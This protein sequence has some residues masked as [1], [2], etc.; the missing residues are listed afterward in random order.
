MGTENFFSNSHTSFIPA[1]PNFHY[2]GGRNFHRISKGIYRV[3][4]HLQR[5]F[6]GRKSGLHHSPFPAQNED[7]GP[8]ALLLSPAQK[9]RNPFPFWTRTE[10]KTFFQALGGGGE[11]AKMVFRL[12]WRDMGGRV[13]AAVL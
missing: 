8:L 13:H 5:F 4:T 7:R 6:F 12:G 2:A 3:S 10:V 11:E 9:R 1:P